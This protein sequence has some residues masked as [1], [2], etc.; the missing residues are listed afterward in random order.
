MPPVFQKNSL[1]SLLHARIQCPCADYSGAVATVIG[2][3]IAANIGFLGLI[4]SKE[5]KTSEFRQA[6][7]D[8]LSKRAPAFRSTS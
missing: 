8:A 2:A 7:I 5:Q 4:V 1:A 3:S 6:S